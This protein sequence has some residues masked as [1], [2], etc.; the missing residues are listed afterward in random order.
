MIPIIPI[1]P[2]I[3]KKVVKFIITSYFLDFDFAINL[4]PK[5][6]KITTTPRPIKNNDIYSISCFIKPARITPPKINLAISKQNLPASTNKLFFSSIF[7]VSFLGGIFVPFLLL[8][9]TFDAAKVQQKFDIC[10]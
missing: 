4:K 7:A 1:A 2:T 3:K 8:L 9:I 10:K 6:A 5:K